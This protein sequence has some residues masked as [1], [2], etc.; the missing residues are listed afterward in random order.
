LCW[1]F[2]FICMHSK[3]INRW[4]KPTMLASIFSIILGVIVVPQVQAQATSPT[5][6]CNASR[7]TCTVT[8]TYAGDYYMWPVPADVRTMSL[9]ISG[10]Q[11]GRSGGNGTK[12]LAT[13]KTIPTGNLYIYVG[14]QGSSGNGAAGGYNGGGQAGSGHGD[15]GSGGGATDIRTST[16]LTDRIAVAAGG[17]GTGGWIGGS[18]GMG[19]G[20]TGI[21]GGNG[22]GLGGGG[23]TPTVGGAGGSSYGAA[24]TPGTAGSLGQGGTG[25][26]ANT[27]GSTVAGGGGGGG[28]YFGGGGGGADTDPVGVDGGGGGAGSS[29]A[30]STK[31]QSVAYYSGTQAGDGVAS[32]TYT[33]SPSVT[34]FTA[35]A[36]PSNAVNPVFNITFGQSITGITADDFTISG[37]ATGCYVS[38]LVGSGANYA[39]TVAGCSDGTIAL[40]LKAD[41]VS[42]NV[43]G[44]V[45]PVSTS[46]IVLDRTLPEINSLTKQPST[47]D[48]VIYKAVF[49]ETVT[50][51]AADSTD[52]LVKGN[53]C[54]IQSM[55]GTGTDY[56]ITISNCLDGNLAGLVLNAL[57]VVDTAGNIGPSLAN[58]TGA[59]KI[60]TKAPVFSVTDVTAPGFGGLPTWVFDSEEPTTGM[61]QAKFVFSGTATSCSMN[62]TVLRSGLGWQVGLTGCGVGTTQVTL[63]ANS[64]ADLAGN[65]GPT[66][67]LASNV[68]TIKADEVVNQSVNP[69]TGTGGG[70]Q[71]VPSSTDKTGPEPKDQFTK[72][73]ALKEPG[74]PQIEV[75]KPVAKELEKQGQ[76]KLVISQSQQQPLLIVIGLVAL[77]IALAS[78]A[79]GSQL[80]IRRRRH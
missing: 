24:T 17:G 55:T 80:R 78:F 10:A 64:V 3:K 1:S 37:T 5:P 69:P 30:N 4:F 9:S 12:T 79:V 36:S 15:E 40:T 49:T 8:F 54:V 62:Y 14:G 33:F 23:G 76:E 45:R 58:Q 75:P 25:G 57:A 19:S 13:F 38:T 22:Q 32:I 73:E 53:G 71:K 77:A 28:G 50:G 63:A 46:T 2:I 47:N 52:W 61:T 42:G 72:P 59:T 26:S 68:I 21:A 6:S 74:Q 66:T 70:I 67:A 11:G 39:A 7:T 16:L 20:T 29:Y 41:S 60:D 18:G 65:L 27:P 44:P 43:L 48:L 56:V 35:P 51:L 34:S 31:L